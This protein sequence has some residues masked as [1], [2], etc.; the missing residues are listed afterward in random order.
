MYTKSLI[1]LSPLTLHTNLD[2]QIKFNIVTLSGGTYGLLLNFIV[3][4]CD[5][6]TLFA[7][8][9]QFSNDDEQTGQY[10]ATCHLSTLVQSIRLSILY[11]MIGLTGY[12]I[13]CLMD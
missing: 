12:M 4:F 9:L 8:F 2:V 3:H 7:S 13:K 6:F 10:C 1:P 5:F 11:M